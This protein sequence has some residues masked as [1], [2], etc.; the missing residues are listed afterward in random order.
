[1]PDWGRGVSMTHAQQ[2]RFSALDLFRGL[3]ALAVVAFHVPLPEGALSMAPR[4]YLAVDL[5][6]VLSGFVLAHAYGE[7]LARGGGMRQF[8][9]QRLIRLYPLY[10]IALVSGALLLLNRLVLDGMPA[11]SYTRWAQGLAAN[12]FFLPAPIDETQASAALFPSLFVAWSL[13]W[14]LAANLLFALLAPWLGKRTLAAAMIGGLVPMVAIAASAGTLN[15][16][17]EWPALWNGGA[18]VLWSFFAGVA[19]FRLHQR[20]AWRLA[21]PDWLLA[22]LLVASFLPAMGGWVYDVALA[23]IGFPLLVLLGARARRRRRY[24]GRSAMGSAGC[25]TVSM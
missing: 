23:V 7:Q 16:G 15:G 19:L 24:R 10:L 20:L 12:L 21:A 6:F 2:G 11:L 4:G 25:P 3:A 17:A 1:M 18:R 14:E 8:L 13:M 22:L 5:F 9:V